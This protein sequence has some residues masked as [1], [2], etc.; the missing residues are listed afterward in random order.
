MSMTRSL[1]LGLTLALAVVWLAATGIVRTVFVHEI[2]EIIGDTLAKS[3]YR[4][5]PL[6]IHAVSTQDK[7]DSEESDDGPVE[8]DDDLVHLN[9]GLDGFLAFQ[10]SAPDGRVMLQSHDAALYAFPDMHR[11]GLNHSGDLISFTLADRPSGL[12]LTVIEPEGHRAEA[13]REAT[14][15]MLLPLALMIPLMAGAV[16]WLARRAVG[17]VQD[18][19]QSIATR[20]GQNLTPVDDPGLPSELRAIAQSVDRL[21]DRLRGAMAAERVFAANAAHEMRTPIA[22]ALA[23]TQRL[24]AELPAGAGRDRATEVEGTL[25]RLGRLTEKL[26]QLSRAEAAGGVPAQR[27]NM[28]PVVD[29]VLRDLGAGRGR[30]SVSDQLNQDLM[31][32]MDADDFAICL[33]NLLENALL[34][35]VGAVDLVIGADWTVHVINGGPVVPLDGLT[36]RFARGDTRADGAG[37]GLAIVDM[38][39]RQAGGALDLASPATGRGDGFEAVLRLP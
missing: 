6:V 32:T 1:I 15:A 21:L 31:V 17:P 16:L 36:D 10:V 39:M 34:H 24:I 20:G 27:Q 30:V 37:L 8:L 12:T 11:P 33:R 14:M 25:H 26:L 23:Q 29:M 35:G 7:G 4:I 18:L 2:D 3:A 19:R 9:F 5:M 13:I 38:V 22:G 28:S